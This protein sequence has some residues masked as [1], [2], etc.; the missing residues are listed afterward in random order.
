MSDRPESKQR[1]RKLGMDRD[2][3]RR[4]FLNGVNIAIAG[5]LL[6]APLARVIAA[7]ADSA[8]DVSAQM[9]GACGRYCAVSSATVSSIPA[10]EGVWYSQGAGWCS[11]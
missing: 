11:G 10:W 1:D 3:T 7:Q 4:D 6:S 9:T 2:I 8:G 5:S